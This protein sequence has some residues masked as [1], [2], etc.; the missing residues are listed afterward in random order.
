MI[1]FISEN[2]ILATAESVLKSC[3]IWPTRPCWKQRSPG[4]SGILIC[5]GP[6]NIAWREKDKDVHEN[7]H[8]KIPNKQIMSLTMSNW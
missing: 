6:K 2:S 4:Y 7:E 8:V 1:L 3:G 5:L